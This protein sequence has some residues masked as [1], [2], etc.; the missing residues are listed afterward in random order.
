MTRSERDEEWR[1]LKAETVVFKALGH[2]VRLAFLRQLAGGPR[3]VCELDPGRPLRSASVSRHL[4]ILKAAGL[5]TDSR[6][7]KRNIY[8][9]AL[10]E[11][12]VVMERVATMVRRRFGRRL[13]A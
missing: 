4:A 1:L 5:V 7:G 13:P 6:D 12:P 9:L 2:P 10:A 11:L 3:C 8:S